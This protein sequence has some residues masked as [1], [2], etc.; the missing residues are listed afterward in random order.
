MHVQHTTCTDAVLLSGKHVLLNFDAVKKTKNVTFLLVPV[1]DPEN[2]CITI[3]A[4]IIED[5]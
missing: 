5:W 4:E 2:G 3:G 1:V